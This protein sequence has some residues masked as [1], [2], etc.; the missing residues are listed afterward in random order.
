MRVDK[1]TMA[2][3]V[4][5]RAPFLDHRLVELAARLPLDM[6]WREGE[7]KL[8]LKR[9]LDGIV[10]GWVLERK[11]QGFGAP[12]W[13]WLETLRPLAERELLRPAMADHLETANV[14]ALLDGP[15][16]VQ[17]GFELWILLNF[18]LWHRHFVE[19]ADLRDSSLMAVTGAAA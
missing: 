10:P 7:G 18:A 5:G 16:T 1:M 12:V 8:L 3:S 11:K 9:A 15:R 4:E 17:T 13:R 6:H 2:A 19:G 14:R